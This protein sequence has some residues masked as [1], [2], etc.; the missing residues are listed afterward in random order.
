MIFQSL[1]S[2]IKKLYRLT[3]VDNKP[4]VFLFNDTQIVDESFLEDINNILSSGEVPNLY[5]QDEFVEVCTVFLSFRPPVCLSVS[6]YYQ[7]LFFCLSI[8][9]LAHL[10]YKVTHK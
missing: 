4:T 6:V 5:K 2:D 9:I 3:G 7:H 1:F 10:F 8:C